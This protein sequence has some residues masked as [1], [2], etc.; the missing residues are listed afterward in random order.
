MPGRVE[1]LQG[2]NEYNQ[3]LW[4]DRSAKIGKLLLTR[5]IAVAAAKREQKKIEYLS[6]VT[7]DTERFI[8]FRHM[9]GYEEEL[10]SVADDYD[11][12]ALHI[13]SESQ[14]KRAK[15]PRGKVLSDG[16]T[17]D[18]LI[19][20]FL[21]HPESQ[22][23]RARP[24]WRSFFAELMRLNL[25]PEKNSGGSNCTFGPEGKRRKLSFGRFRNLVSKH[26]KTF[27]LTG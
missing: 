16:A 15:R 3:R 13:R 12:H 17:V 5:S 8:L 24:L 18:Q 1:S 2:L 9:R 10:E 4:K 6:L 19:D 22:G 26:K 14:R 20:R 27:T 21:R 7:D 23:L 25:N 11:S